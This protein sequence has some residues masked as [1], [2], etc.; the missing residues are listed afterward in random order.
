LTCVITIN[1]TEYICDNETK[2]FN[3][4][5]KDSK[6]EEAKTNINNTFNLYRLDNGGLSDYKEIGS[7]RLRNEI[8]Y[9]P[10]TFKK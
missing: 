8:T 1:S 5:D 6:I 9:T 2:A 7:N 10:L 3:T 4:S